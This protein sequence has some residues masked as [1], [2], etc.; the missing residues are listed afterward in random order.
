MNYYKLVARILL[1]LVFKGHTKSR[2]WLWSFV[3]EKVSVKCV[4]KGLGTTRPAFLAHQ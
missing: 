4:S 1:H 2:W 3:A